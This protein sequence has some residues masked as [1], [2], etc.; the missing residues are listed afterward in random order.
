MTDDKS[1]TES[2]HCLKCNGKCF[3]MLAKKYIYISNEVIKSESQTKQLM[4]IWN[5][6]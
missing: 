3:E 6:L 4:A 1:D 5:S 2:D